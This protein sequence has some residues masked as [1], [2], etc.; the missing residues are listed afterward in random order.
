MI[1]QWIF[2]HPNTCKSRFYCRRVAKIK[3]LQVQKTQRFPLIFKHVLNPFW[4]TFST[5]INSFFHCICLTK[6]WLFFQAFWLQNTP[7]MD[8]KMGPTNVRKSEE[9]SQ[10]LQKCAQTSKNT[11]LEPIW[12]HF[13]VILVS[14]LAS[15]LIAFGTYS[16]YWFRRNANL[17]SHKTDSEN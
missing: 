5:N 11:I 6:F 10:G 3:V 4:A 17:T 14:F 15:V 12:C 9:A 7:K 16:A 1:F 8:P 13:G 2:D